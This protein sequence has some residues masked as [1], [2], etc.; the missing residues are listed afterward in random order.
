[1]FA[2]AANAELVH[3]PY[4][5]S[6]VQDFLGGQFDLLW[7]GALTSVQMIQDGQVRVLAVTSPRRIAEM[8]CGFN[9]PTQQLC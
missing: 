4:R 6:P 5:G 9:R 8:P 1:M 7:L 3:V 2:R